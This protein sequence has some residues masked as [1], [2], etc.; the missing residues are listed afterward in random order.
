MWKDSIGGLAG[1]PVEHLGKA[2]RD[3]MRRGVQVCHLKSPVADVVAQMTKG[4]ADAVVVVDA[5]GEAVGMVT[6]QEVMRAYMEDLAEVSAEEIMVPKAQVVA[7]DTLVVEAVQIMLDRG[8]RHLLIKGE[9]RREV[10]VGIIS[11][12]D[13]VREMAGLQ[14]SRPQLKLPKSKQR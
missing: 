3:V 8:V 6:D 9:Q 13:I 7:P 4:N 1:K 2:V 12:A 10:P 5:D 11:A 14:P